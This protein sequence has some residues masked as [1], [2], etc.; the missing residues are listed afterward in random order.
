MPKPATLDGYDRKHTDDCERVLVTLLRGLGPWKKSVFLIGG[1][2]PRYLVS[3]RPPSVAPHA[4]TQ[5][6]DIVIDFQILTDTDAYHSLEENLKR[7]GFQRSV[8]EKKQKLSW[9]WETQTEN[10]AL[11]IV[12]L[13]TDSPELSGGKVTAL[14]T[15]GSI[16]ALNIPHSSIVF[17][18]HD[19]KEITAELLGDKGIATETVRYANIVGFTSLKCFAFDDRAEGKD[20]HDLVYCLEHAQGG[21]DGAAKAFKEAL[22]GK[23]KKTIEL[24]IEILRKRFTDHDDEG[25]RRDGP[26][27]VA[28]F[29]LG[30]G[31]TDREARILRQRQVNALV[32]R[33]LTQLSQ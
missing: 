3:A 4:G 29:E 25:Y 12:E 24:A 11:M 14:P 31:A 27:A 13:L 1:L 26:V 9:R 8:N 28:K 15:E 22:S 16:S 20:A 10:K 18:L 6:V 30:D 19:S 21:I 5:D 33:L 7:M 23:H 2:A 17:D 32:Q